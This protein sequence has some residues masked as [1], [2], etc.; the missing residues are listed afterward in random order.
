[1]NVKRTFFFSIQD[2]AEC[3]IL[4]GLA[5]VL[6]LFIKVPVGITGGSAGTAMIPLVFLALHK[7]WFKGFLSAGVVFGLI[8]CLTDGY[9]FVTYPMEYLI[10]FGSVA[11]VG[12][13]RKFI[14]VDEGDPMPIHYVMFACSIVLCMAIRT[15]GGVIDS[16]VIY[17]YDFYSSLTYN[18]S[19]LLPTLILL[20]IFLVPFLKPFNNMIRRVK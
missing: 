6:D 9:G 17:E 14:L 5:I 7:G 2:I 13:L 10:G 12:A 20:L 8:T 11:V 1:M 3:G 18:L 15:M 4:V 16:M 19:Y